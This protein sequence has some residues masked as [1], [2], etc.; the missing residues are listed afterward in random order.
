M[1][2]FGEELLLYD[3]RQSWCLFTLF[4]MQNTRH[5]S[6][7]SVAYARTHIHEPV[8]EHEGVTLL[9]NEWVHTKKLRLIG[10]M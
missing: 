8:R 4:S 3:T 1:P 2:H 5:K 6:N 10:Q 7:R 9:R